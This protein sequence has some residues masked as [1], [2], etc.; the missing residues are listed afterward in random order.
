MGTL[1]GG[2]ELLSKKWKY[3]RSHGILYKWVFFN[4]NWRQLV[5]IS[6]WIEDEKIKLNH[7]KE[8]HWMDYLN[9]INFYQNQNDADL[10]TMKVILNIKE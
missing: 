5:N 3:H 9:A 6:K 10:P 1:L 2:A 4:P 7:V 8:F